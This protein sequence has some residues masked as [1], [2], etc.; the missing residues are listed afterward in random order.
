[1]PNHPANSF[2]YPDLNDLPPIATF[3]FVKVIKTFIFI[4]KLKRKR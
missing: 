1:M 3:F 4:F 2:Y